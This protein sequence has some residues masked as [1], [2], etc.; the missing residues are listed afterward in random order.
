MAANRLLATLALVCTIFSS[1]ASAQFG[2]GT[3]SVPTRLTRQPVFVIPFHLGNSIDASEV[4]LFYSENL[5]RDWSRYARQRPD[6][7]GFQFRASQDGEYWFAVRTF[8]QLG[9]MVGHTEW[10]P[11]LKV[12]VDTRKPELELRAQLDSS[13]QVATTW[14]TRDKNLAPA[15]FRLQ[16]QDERGEWRDVRVTQPD[17]R[18]VAPRELRDNWQDEVA[19]RLERPVRELNLRAEVL[20]R[21]G[22]VTQIARRV[23]VTNVAS[24]TDTRFPAA[25][26]PVDGLDSWRREQPGSTGWS[27]GAASQSA[28]PFAANR[29]Q[30]NVPG[31]TNPPR[32]DTYGKTSGGPTD[33]QSTNVNDQYTKRTL[34]DLPAWANFGTGIDSLLGGVKHTDLHGAA[35]VSDLNAGAAKPT[36]SGLNWG[37]GNV[38][39]NQQPQQSAV[40]QPVGQRMQQGFGSTTEQR[41]TNDLASTRSSGGAPG[42]GAAPDFGPAPGFGTAPD[43][44]PATSVGSAP[45]FG[46]NQG[47]AGTSPSRPRIISSPNFSLD[48]DVY[49]AGA[50]G[51]RLVELWFTR[52]EGRTWELFGSDADRVSP[53][54]VQLRQEGI[55]GFRLVVHGYGTATSSPR[56]GDR[57]D[58][59]V[60]VDWTKPVGRITRAKLTE[61]FPDNELTID[62]LAE[63]TLLVE[64]PIS[65][66]YSTTPNATWIPIANNLRNSGTYRWRIPRTMPTNMML[67]IS[68][69]D[70]AGNVTQSVYNMGETSSAGAPSGRIRNIQIPRRTTLRPNIFESR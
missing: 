21:A 3:D 66:A 8:D 10:R 49:D 7:K 69:R 29:Y 38:A 50:Q 5:G 54:E 9:R 48:Y 59:W 53:F 11:E 45:D 57:A 30:Q 12:I 43:M 63:D 62:W 67:Q 44:G 37:G 42:F 55:Y 65:L 70:V 36:A 15:S 58:A 47:L 52:D 35:R 2:P 24:R 1:V 33:W 28:D 31:N 46:S 51:P 14:A 19:W 26:N 61:G 56:S 60:A 39:S 68:V 41:R 23:G 17:D 27:G 6:A 13:G 18:G 22:N 32:V 16:F 34:P 25:G 4:Q 64:T 20:D 40:Q